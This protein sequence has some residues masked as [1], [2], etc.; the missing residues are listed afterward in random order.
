MDKTVL[1]AAVQAVSNSCSDFNEEYEQYDSI[2]LKY[3]GYVD[4]VKTIVEEADKTTTDEKVVELLFIIDLTGSMNTYVSDLRFGIDY[5]I[6]AIKEAAN[7]IIENSVDVRIAFIG[8]RDFTLNNDPTPIANFTI[9][10]FT[11]NSENIKTFLD[12]VQIGGGDDCPEDVYGA[13]KLALIGISDVTPITWS[14]DTN[15]LRYIIMI[16]DERPHG[17]LFRKNTGSIIQERDNFPNAPSNFT[18]FFKEMKKINISE[19]FIVKLNTQIDKMLEEFK[20]MNRDE[21]G[22]NIIKITEIDIK[23]LRPQ[24]VTPIGLA[25]PPAFA[26]LMD[27]PIRREYAGGFVRRQYAGDITTHEISDYDLLP[28]FAGGSSSRE[29]SMANIVT[30]EVTRSV[31]VGFADMLVAQ[32]ETTTNPESTE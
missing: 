25:P 15:T 2:F 30:R 17:N 31:T 14:T 10:P 4:I 32:R 9:H 23:C 24:D 27:Y 19:F 22:E 16:G 21:N 13:F 12:R 8:Y 18:P 11:K 7:T 6:S 26:E 29:Y 1:S 3:K 20:K 5:M 28:T